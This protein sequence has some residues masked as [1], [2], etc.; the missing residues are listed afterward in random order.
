MSNLALERWGIP[1]VVN[2][3]ERDAIWP[4]PFLN[5]RVQNLG[6]GTLQ[7]YTAGG[8]V[9]DFFAGALATGTP[10]IQWNGTQIVAQPQAINFEGEGVGSVVED[11]TT[12]KVVIVSGG[13][14][15]FRDE[16]TPVVT[17]GALDVVG[18]GAE[19]TDNAGVA[20]L[21]V[22]GMSLSD[23][24]VDLGP[25]D[26]L[27][28]DGIGYALGVA[29]REGTL[30][31]TGGARSTVTI[32]TAPLAQ[33]ATETGTVAAT[34]L[35]IWEIVQ[36]ANKVWF[37]VYATA[38]DRTADAARLITDDP[39][40]PVL[41]EQIF[42][43]TLTAKLPPVIIANED[44]PVQ[45]VVYWSIKMLEATGGGGA[46]TPYV[47]DMFTPVA[48]LDGHT[49]TNPG[50]TAW[51]AWEYNDVSSQ[52]LINSFNLLEAAPGI[53]TDVVARSDVDLLNDNFAAFIDA[54]RFSVDGLIDSA[55]FYFCVPN[56]AIGGYNN[57]DCY[58]V[59]IV[60][61]SDATVRLQVDA[62][63]AGGVVT[64]LAS[65]GGIAMPLNTGLRFGFRVAGTAVTTYTADFSSGA[66]EVAHAPAV[67]A[68]IAQ[69]A[70]HERMG[71]GA[72]RQLGSTGILPYRWAVTTVTAPGA[73]IAA[74]IAVTMTQMEGVPL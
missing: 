48:A 35:S 41:F 42:N 1:V 12:A 2:A 38:A 31:L 58:R 17:A 16:G 6:T 22:P 66:N 13:A 19:V 50:A 69:D 37:R 72:K 11:G 8:W 56:S 74:N 15:N 23:R 59:S 36:S 20:Q 57:D 61:D 47:S 14:I 62:I 24:S 60:R 67:L 53:A 70:T 33:D 55:A 7:R 51:A 29:S 49:P 26:R 63:A 34:G 44:V 73:P 68:G 52:Y 64:A 46:A 3:A 54:Y 10:S 40:T 4:N 32:N 30:T 71:V 28:L 25:I 39:T 43:P 65:T 5:Q 18:D 21:S 9:D 45:G 27:I